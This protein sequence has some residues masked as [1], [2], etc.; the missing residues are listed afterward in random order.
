[1]VF[2]TEVRRFDHAA[3]RGGVSVRDR[4]RGRTRRISVTPSGR[5]AGDA[6]LPSISADGRFATFRTEGIFIRGPLR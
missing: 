6:D 4:R 1:V 5:A 2:L 3:V